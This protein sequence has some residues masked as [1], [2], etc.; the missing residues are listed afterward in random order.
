MSNK[1][2]SFSSKYAKAG[3]TVFISGG[4]LVLCFF[5]LNNLEGVGAFLKKV[6]GI[7]T[8]FYLGII[9]AY[10]LCP[11][12]NGSLRLIYKAN[13]GRVKNTV[14]AYRFSRF[15]A[16]VIALFTLIFILSGL[17][18]LV[19]PE[20][21]DSI[22]GLIKGLPETADRISIWI[23]EN[24]EQNPE[25]VELL[26]GRIESFSETF[27]QWAQT[28]VLPGAESILAGVSAGVVGT[29][30]GVI[31]VLVALV[32]CVYV[33]NSKEIFQAQAKKFILAA[34]SKKRADDIFEFGRIC[35]E[36][37]GGFINGKIIDSIIIG[38]LCFI[39]MTVLKLP[40]T[41]L[42]SVVVGVTNIIPFFG[43]FIGA[44]PSIVLL[45]C[46]EPWSAVEFGI[47]VL[48]LQQLDG[49]IIGPKILGKTTKLAS[50]WVMFAIIV[51]GGM[52]G[53]VG[54]ILGV[55]TMAVIYVYLTRL[56]NNRLGAKQLPVK[57]AVYEDF[58]KYQINKEDIFGKEACAEYT[59]AEKET[60]EK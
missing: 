30:G 8:P 13:R 21:I 40:L 18:M 57:T 10:L 37:F 23:Q 52:F 11:I 45:L 60:A 35:N 58:T 48:V 20:L 6:N 54:M 59:G 27:F 9:M 33:L 22:V 7:L 56:V 29:I 36:T 39:A 47:M 46:I 14:R 32:I 16:T 44:I 12:Y 31:D 28:N 43:P 53:F 42:I 51:G 19:I 24:V 55:P 50:F 5:L 15:F 38:I 4:A 1:K 17:F 26:Q 2:I 34:F 41:M 25:L 49:N 3:L